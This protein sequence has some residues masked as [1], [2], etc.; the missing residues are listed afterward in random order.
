MKVIDAG[1]DY[2]LNVLD[3]P[4]TQSLR[5]VKRVGPK[6][7]GNT[8]AYSGT[9]MQ[10][11]L[12]AVID[13]AR[14]VNNQIPCAETSKVIVLCTEAVYQLELRAAVRHGRPTDFSVTD[15]VNESFC[16]E[17]GHIRCVGDC[18]D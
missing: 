15:A 16:S 1:H 5:F 6:F 14:Y 11:V 2:E 13:R 17:C 18:H 9:T 3:G 12:R 10:E 4:S 7:P 8:T